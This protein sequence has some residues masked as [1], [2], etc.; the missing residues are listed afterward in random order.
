MVICNLFLYLLKYNIVQQFIMNIP[1]KIELPKYHETFIPVLEILNSVE[2]INSRE[3]TLLVRDKYYSDL[4]IELL[5]QAL[6][7]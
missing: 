6:M 4:P 7:F 3:L 2:S 1:N 5:V